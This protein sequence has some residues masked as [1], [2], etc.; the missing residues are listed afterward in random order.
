MGSPMHFRL[1]ATFLTWNRVN[2]IQRLKEINLIWDQMCSSLLCVWLRATGD[3]VKQQ[4]QLTSELCSFHKGSLCNSSL[5]FDPFFCE[6]VTRIYGTL[7]STGWRW[8]WVNSGS[9]W[10]TGRHGVLR[11]MGS[12]RVGHNWA[13]ELIPLLK[14][15]NL[16]ALG[17]PHVPAHSIWF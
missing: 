3:H 7:S 6:L 4:K 15:F 16:S 13:T 5:C 12:Q 9:W 10:W 17:W 2:R 14:P 11:F 1:Y 8:V